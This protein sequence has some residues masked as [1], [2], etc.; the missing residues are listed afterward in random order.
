MNDR[1]S[2]ARPTMR[3]EATN[4]NLLVGSEEPCRNQEPCC[5]APAPTRPTKMRPVTIEQL[6]YGY[7]VHVGCQRFAVETHEKV[8]NAL[9]EYMSNPYETEKKWFS[10]EKIQLTNKNL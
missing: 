5:E 4:R 9:N 7:L 1:L 3:E 10:G 6:D 8:I 2:D